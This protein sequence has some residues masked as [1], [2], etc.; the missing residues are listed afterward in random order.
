MVR[1][2]TLAL[3]LAALGAACASPFGG[4]GPVADPWDPRY[5]YYGDPYYDEERRDPREGLAR[6][7]VSDKVEH[8]L[9]VAVDGSE[10]Q[11]S[12]GRW[13]RVEVG[14]A[15]WCYWRMEDGGVGRMPL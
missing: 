11:V 6:K 13:K 9:L 14:D 3:L 1:T 12:A 7:K 10:C 8:T 15:V 5:P 2:A 4:Y